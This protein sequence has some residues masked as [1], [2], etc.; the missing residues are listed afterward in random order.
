M[1][2]I[3]SSLLLLTGVALEGNAQSYINNQTTLQ[4]S[5]N[6]YISGTAQ[7]NTLKPTAGTNATGVAHFH[8][9][10]GDGNTAGNLRWTQSFIGLEGASNAGADFRIFRYSNTGAFLGT[11]LAIERATGNVVVNNLTAANAS[12][13]QGTGT[14]AKQS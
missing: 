8:M 14:T 2:K 9:Y 6:F 13:I 7:S 3:I 11:G 4:P 5:S 1:K 12:K 10:T